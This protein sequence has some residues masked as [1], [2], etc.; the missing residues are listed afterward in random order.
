MASFLTTSPAEWAVREG[1]LIIYGG[2]AQ[3]FAL[4]YRSQNDRRQLDGVQ[5]KVLGTPESLVFMGSS[6]RWSDGCSSELRH[7]NVSG[8]RITFGTTIGPSNSC[9]GSG[10]GGTAHK[11]PGFDR[12]A[13]GTVTWV[14]SGRTLTLTKAGV[15]SLSLTNAGAAPMLVGTDWTLVGVTEPRTGTQMDVDARAHLVIDASGQLHASD[16]CNELTG[17]AQV[18]Q[19]AFTLGPVKHA[20]RP[21]TGVFARG[22][23]AIDRLLSGTV[24]YAITNDEL[25]LSKPNSGNVAIYAAKAGQ[26][27]PAQLTGTSWRLAA[28]TPLTNRSKGEV[29]TVD[30]RFNGGQALTIT[31]CYESG[32]SVTIA[33]GTMTVRGLHT[34]LARP[35]PSGPRG[36]QQQNDFIDGV[37]NGELTWSVIGG[38][39]RIART[40]VGILTFTRRR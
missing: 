39:L 32:A 26:T 17:S 33:A 8:G 5:W 31:R 38:E 4:V 22:A 7:V 13:N 28:T 1:K 10:A 12:I 16:Q 9:S 14:V 23:G 20:D 11:G 6:V 27:E 35:C 29:G 24:Q 19:D 2:G 25:V 21:C 34:T 40:D 30:L 15:G 36:T 37:L 3:A 18:T